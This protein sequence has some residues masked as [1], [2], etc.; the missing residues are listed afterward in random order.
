MRVRAGGCAQ[1]LSLPGLEAWASAWLPEGVRIPF[2]GLDQGFEAPPQDQTL[3]L[4]P[5]RSPGLPP[6]MSFR[7]LRK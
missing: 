7:V 1:A 5:P 3:P 4:F 2:S 6:S